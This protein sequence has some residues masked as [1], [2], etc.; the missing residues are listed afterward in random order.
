MKALLDLSVQHA[1]E[2]P[3]QL[4]PFYHGDA[5]LEIGRISLQATSIYIYRYILVA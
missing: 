1:D 5:A 2:Q 3:L 4:D